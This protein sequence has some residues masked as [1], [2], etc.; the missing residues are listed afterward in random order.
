LNLVKQIEA[1]IP[2]G[3]LYEPSR[4]LKSGVAIA[5]KLGA[6][7]LILNSRNIRKKVLAEA[8]ENKILIGEYPIDTKSRFDQAWKNGINILFSNQPAYLRSLIK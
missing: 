4:H 8:R 6:R 1:S 5:R 3:F 2:F 7:Y